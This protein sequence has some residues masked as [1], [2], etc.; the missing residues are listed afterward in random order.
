MLGDESHGGATAAP[1]TAA[2]V[3]RAP[4]LRAA[5][6]IT[7]KNRKDELVRAVESAL[8]QS[9]RPEVLV[10]DDGSTDGSAQA[11]AGRFPASR[12]PQLRVIRHEHSAGY[13]ARRNEAAAA[14]TADVVVSI[15][16]DATFS[17]PRV[18]EQTLREFD[19]PRVGA[20]A[21]PYVDVTYS[22]EVV[23]KAPSPDGCWCA[24][25]FRGTA[26]ALR[27]EL[28]LR[29]GAYR[30][31][32]V[33]QNEEPDFCNRLCD[34]GYVVRLGTADPVMHYESPKRDRRRVMYFWLR[35]AVLIAWYNVPLPYLIV[36]LPAIAAIQT[37]RAAKQGYL[38]SALRGVTFGLA[39]IFKQWS[40]RKPVSRSTYRV[41]RV[42]KKNRAMRLKDVIAAGL[43]PA[44]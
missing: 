35:N 10:V 18:I 16:D 8:G 20:V 25:V 17:S 19:E 32:L 14:T 11:V 28:F 36:H 1:E 40:Q 2:T 30:P 9:A 22:P 26:H 33:H 7:S 27:R 41:L 31:F 44:R 12:Y 15:D 29:L 43:S 42:L 23:Q 34:A 21:M 39:H 4:T 13:I 38:G 5:V 37:A 24:F 6:V 3:T